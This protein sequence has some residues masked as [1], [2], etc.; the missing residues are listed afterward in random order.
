MLRSAHEPQQEN[1]FPGNPGKR[2]DERSAHPGLRVRSDADADAIADSH[3]AAHGHARSG[4][5]TNARADAN[6]NA[7]AA[8]CDGGADLAGP[9]SDCA[10]EGSLGQH[11]GTGR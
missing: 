1:S 9:A 4:A 3:P 5:D 10:D 7:I 8:T 2:R 11:P 6:A